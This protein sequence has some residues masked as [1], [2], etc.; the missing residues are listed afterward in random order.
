MRDIQIH[1]I[2]KKLENTDKVIIA[3]G[4]SFAEGQGAIYDSLYDNYKWHYQG[5]GK[6]MLVTVSD[7]EKKEIMYQYP[8][9]VTVDK[10][11]GKLDFSI[12]EI[13]NSFSHVLAEKYFDNEYVAIN[14]GIRGTGNRGQI[15]E[16]YFRPEINW[17]RVKKIIV[18]YCVS[19]IERF[20]FVNDLWDTHY[21]WK[22]MWP[23]KEIDENDRKPLWEGYGQ[24]VY[25][26]KQAII[27]QIANVQ[28]LLTWCKLH[29]ASL[30]ITPGFEQRYTKEY[31]N[32]NLNTIVNRNSRQEII[33][34]SFLKNILDVKKVSHDYLS[35]L[36]PWNNMFYPDD[37]DTFIR[38]CMSQEND[39][40]KNSTDW[41]WQ[42]LGNR[43]PKG[44]I[45][46][47]AHPGE[48]GHDLFAKHLYFHILKNNL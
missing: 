3:L 10:A 2:N 1:R 46:G 32:E 30:I 15:K 33:E 4:C 9:K 16:L 22:A 39:E 41:F 35:L 29:N 44:Y 38:L 6:G 34:N 31:F 13:E 47:C 19:G 27:E 21:H 36:W 20:D 28:E 40:I 25:S 26:E 5:M 14:M 8:D 17:H 12:M 7:S 48:K 23:K 24:T 43:S 42:F 11:S 37:N 45:T 18:V